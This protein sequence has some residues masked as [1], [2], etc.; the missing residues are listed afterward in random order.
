MGFLAAAAGARGN[1]AATLSWGDVEL[2]DE[3]A[4][5]AGMHALPRQCET[6]VAELHAAHRLSF[7]RWQA[8]PPPPFSPY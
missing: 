3:S 8:P 5:A 2:A 7:P 4:V 1:K 6:G